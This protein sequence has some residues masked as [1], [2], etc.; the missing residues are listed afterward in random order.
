VDDWRRSQKGNLWQRLDDGRAVTV[1]ERDDGTYSWCIADEDGPTW[2]RSRYGT[3]EEA[4]EA[5]EARLD[6]GD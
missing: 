1:F 2:S 5:V 3:E 4:L 6:E